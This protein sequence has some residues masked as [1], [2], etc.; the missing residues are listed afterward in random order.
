MADLP[1]LAA[2]LQRAEWDGQLRTDAAA[3]GAAGHDFGGIV[4]RPP[5]AA[6]SAGSV[7]DVARAVCLAR[8]AGL[9]VAARGRGHTTFGQAQAENGL[10]VEMSALDAILRIESDRVQVEAGATW[11]AL[12]AATLSRSLMPPVLT[13]YL[14]LTV[15]GTLSVGGLGGASHR[16]GA[17]VDHV[18]ELVVVTGTGEL[19]TC[20]PARLPE[21]FFAALAGLGQC[22]IIVNARLRL[23]PAP[24]MARVYNLLYRDPSSLLGDL[25]RLVVEDRFDHLA[26]YLLP[27]PGGGWA[28]ALEAARYA[29]S[30]AGLDDAQHLAG[31]GHHTGQVQVRDYAFAAF[32]GR[33]AEQAA[34][35]R[36]RG[37]WERPHPWFDAFVPGSDIEAFVEEVLATLTHT[38]LGPSF[39]LLLYP[40]RT[41]CFTRPLLRLPSEEFACL[42]DLLRTAPTEPRAVE[43]MLARNRRLFER[44][45]DGGGTYY[46]VGAVPL[47]PEDWRRHFGVAWEA[48]AAAKQRFDPGSVL[49]PGPGIF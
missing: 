28:A 18:L 1:S 38:D 33:L 45:R 36:R 3:R 31:L 47:S 48:F 40:V 12:L 29:A 39:P 24:A 11:S 27:A 13:D 6:L 37:E 10:V 2:D 49:T 44:N 5:L 46:P 9:R 34:L 4:Q 22:G 8:A 25:R 41:D 19:E 14:D 16:H 21:L 35:L 7:A 32:A 15:G 30:P 23:V 26:A 42:F 43:G 20:S 17:Q